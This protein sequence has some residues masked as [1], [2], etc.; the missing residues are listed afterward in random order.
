MSFLWKII[1]ITSLASKTWCQMNLSLIYLISLGTLIGYDKKRKKKLLKL[2]RYTNL[3]SCSLS[4]LWK[5]ILITLLAS[6]T[7][8]QM[9]L[10]LIYLI[11]L[12]T[13]I[14]YDKKRK[15][16]LLKLERY[17]IQF[18]ESLITSLMKNITDDIP[19][20]INFMPS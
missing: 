6:K 3:K 18:K 19:C 1:L 10:S 14:R 11:S 13:L 4:F 15:K 16:K 12:G 9:N 2:E 17:T 7:W 5:I 8:C 20:I